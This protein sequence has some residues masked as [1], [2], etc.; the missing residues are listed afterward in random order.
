M[1][2]PTPQQP[3]WRASNLERAAHVE[4]WEH[5]DGWECRVFSHARLCRRA[6]FTDVRAAHLEATGWLAL[7]GTD[8]TGGPI[9]GVR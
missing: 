7:L 4:L 5:P 9:G 8:V 3:V 6:V 2:A 1:S